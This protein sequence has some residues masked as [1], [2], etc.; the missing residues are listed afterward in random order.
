[1]RKFKFGDIVYS[2]DSGSK[3]SI[4][5]SL[6]DPRGMVVLRAY[7]T[8]HY[9]IMEQSRLELYGQ[10]MPPPTAANERMDKLAVEIRR[11]QADIRLANDVIYER[12]EAIESW[13][14]KLCES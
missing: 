12:L 5:E 11:L 4:V 10:E 9:D 6:P 3:Y 13:R 14:E 1:M 7:L 2:K 8:G